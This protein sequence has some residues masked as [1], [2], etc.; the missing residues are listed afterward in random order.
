MD[1]LR[2]EMEMEKVRMGVQNVY[3]WNR[4]KLFHLWVFE[5]KTLVRFIVNNF[6][7]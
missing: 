7:F 3:Y 5:I 6:S 2:K 1:F 4:A